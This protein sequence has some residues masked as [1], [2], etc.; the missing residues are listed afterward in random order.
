MRSTALVS[1]F[2]AVALSYPEVLSWYS[3]PS[4]RSPAP[5]SITGCPKSKTPGRDASGGLVSWLSCR[6]GVRR[7][8]A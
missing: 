2:L 3:G 8:E 4:Q 1:G 7:V 5:V 6:T